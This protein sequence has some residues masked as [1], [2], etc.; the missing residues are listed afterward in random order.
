METLLVI[1]D[2]TRMGG[3]RV[4]VAGITKNKECIR[5]VLRRGIMEDWLYEDRQPIIRPFAKITL[6]LIKN[7]PHPPHTED[8]EFDPDSREF[9]GMVA[10]SKRKDYLDRVLDPS[11]DSIFEA[12]IHTENGR[13]YYLQECEGS[14]SLGTIKTQSIQLF[15]HNPCNAWGKRDYRLYFTDEKGCSYDDLSVTDLSLRYYVDFLRERKNFSSIQISNRL[16][17]TFQQSEEVY[18][19]VG[20][21]RPWNPDPNGPKNRCYLQ[22]NGIYTFPNDYL[23]NRCFA[24]F[25]PTEN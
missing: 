20:L 8:W 19:R 24:D 22:I 10:E 1:K 18:L 14:R 13:R 16:T 21:A 9:C 6:N 2:V 23:V 11:V 12:D 17:R 7:D 25:C 4:C 5:P 3:S 15:V